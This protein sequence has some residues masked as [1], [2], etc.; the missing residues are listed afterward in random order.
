MPDECFGAN[1]EY[2]RGSVDL[3]STL[4]GHPLDKMTEGIPVFISAPA[5]LDPRQEASKTMIRR[6]LEANG[7]IWRSIGVTEYPISS[8]IHAVMSIIKACHGGVILGFERLRTNSGLLQRG[9]ASETVTSPQVSASLW[10]QIEA[11]ALF[12]RDLPLLI[13][14]DRDVQGGIFDQGSSDLLIYEIPQPETGNEYLLPVFKKFSAEVRGH[15]EEAN[16]IFDVFLS[17]SGENESQA[18]GVFEFLS[19]QGLRVFFSRESIPNLAQAE[20]MKAINTA[21]DR[22]RHMIVLSASA[23]GFEKPWVEREW[24]MF[25][26]EKLSLRK[27]GNIVVIN[28]GNIDV[29]KLPI[30]LRSQQVVG[31][32]HDGLQEALQFVSKRENR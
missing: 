23:E 7:L 5:T 17:F 2:E 27:S 4:K 6:L 3:Q 14:K 31:L 8:P 24:N 26:N 30:A 1:P 29:S 32:S 15:F 20:Y 11:T 9:N 18:R 21:V 22:S 25:L 28:A 10:H 12:A 13:L 19:S 16:S